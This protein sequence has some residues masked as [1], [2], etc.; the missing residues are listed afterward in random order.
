MIALDIFE[1]KK[2][3][4]FG[5]GASGLSTAIALAASGAQLI[6]FDDKEEN[7]EKARN[8]GLTRQT[9]YCFVLRHA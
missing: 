6:C 1:G 3:A 5:L 9:R 4:L 7:C 2:I 8:F